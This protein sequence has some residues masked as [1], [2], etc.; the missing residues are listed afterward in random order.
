MSEQTQASE[1]EKSG[2]YASVI[3]FSSWACAAITA[4]VSVLAFF[5]LMARGDASEVTE[6]F[7]GRRERS[8]ITG[9]VMMPFGGDLLGMALAVLFAPTSYLVSEEGKQWLEKI[10]VKSVRSARAVSLI[11]VVFGLSFL[12]FFTL[13]LLTDDFKKPL[14]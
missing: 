5:I 10:G 4:I 2:S 3:K 12:T 9:L 8:P 13:A 1:R 6:Q 11:F 7:G 14:L